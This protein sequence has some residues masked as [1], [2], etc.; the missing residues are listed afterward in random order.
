[1]KRVFYGIIF[2]VMFIGIVF[3]I[4]SSPIGKN[5]IENYVKHRLRA[6]DNFSVKTFNYDFNS[7]SAV[8]KKGSNTISVYG[9]FIP[10]DASYDA[11]FKN[12]GELDS[13]LRGEMLSK[14][15]LNYLGY[16]SIAGN[17]VFANGY[18]SIRLQC[19]DKCV[20]V[21]NGNDFN[22]QNL[23]SMLKINLPY[24]EGTNSLNIIIKKD[25]SNAIFT[26][27]GK[28]IYKNLFLKNVKLN[29]E[30]TYQNY[31]NYH[32]FMKVYHKLFDSTV[33]FSMKNGVFNLNGNMD[34][35]MSVFDPI[36]DFPLHGRKNIQFAY[37]NQK[38]TKFNIG[39]E[40]EGFCTQDNINIQLNS[41][42]AKDFFGYI[43]MNPFIKG[44]LNGNIYIT[45]KGNSFNFLIN[46]ASLIPN[47]TINYIKAKTGLKKLSLNV[48]FMKGNFDKNKVIF[49]IL[50]KD[51]TVLFSI[52]NGIYFYNGTYAYNIEILK[53]NVKYL[54]NV[55]NGK[56]KLMKV[57]KNQPQRQEILVY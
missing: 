11:D 33:F 38:I 24:F 6:F 51:D 16:L 9:N 5:L 10:F 3:L 8:L 30:I 32:L 34:A 55:K 18:S 19:T 46:N 57:I 20:G 26:Y 35:N 36:V 23:L 17:A 40:I 4:Y 56:I 15:N 31:S 53:G 44:K 39:K 42:S 12:I 43:D 22:T 2:F 28:F 54:F 7:F 49:N 50:G 47:K 25:K 13:H 27:K 41:L 21:L 45:P 29:G 52:Q 1:M 14:G 48:V 37:T